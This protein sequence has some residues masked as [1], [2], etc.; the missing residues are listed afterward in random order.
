MRENFK[1]TI[2][3]KKIWLV[4]QFWLLGTAFITYIQNIHTY[5]RILILHEE[6]IPGNSMYH[7]VENIMVEKWHVFWT[8]L[9]CFIR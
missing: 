4:Q 2:L 9:I 1:K 6:C 3:F 8:N 5:C 7:N